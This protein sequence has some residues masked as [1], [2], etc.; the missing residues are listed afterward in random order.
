VNP[1]EIHY[2][3]IP[4]EIDAWLTLAERTALDQTMAARHDLVSYAAGILRV[5]AMTQEE[6]KTFFTRF[7]RWVEELAKLVATARIRQD[8]GLRP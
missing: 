4:A 1:E 8:L 5:R 2:I 3:E 7:E 6:H